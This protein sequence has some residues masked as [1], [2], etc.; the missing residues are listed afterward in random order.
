VAGSEDER[1]LCE[2]EGVR[3]GRSRNRCTVRVAVTD[4]GEVILRTI[5]K[6]GVSPIVAVL[7]PAEA[8][9]LSA[10]LASAVRKAQF[11]APRVPVRAGRRT[12]AG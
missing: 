8:L 2:V 10:A 5:D 6:N 9:S 12:V 4:A 11:P 1:I 7:A 3:K